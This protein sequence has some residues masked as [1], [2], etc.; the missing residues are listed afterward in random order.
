MESGLKRENQEEDSLVSD[1]S[2]RDYDRVKVC[3]NK[4]QQT[5]P[6]KWERGI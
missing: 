3:H 4:T 1:D 5:A 2:G 6:E